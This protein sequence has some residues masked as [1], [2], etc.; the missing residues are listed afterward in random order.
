MPPERP[1][2]LPYH[3]ARFAQIT[4]PSVTEAGEA[5]MVTRTVSIAYAI[6]QKLKLA[7]DKSNHDRPPP[8]ITMP[9]ERA[10]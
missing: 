2:D 4:E 5:V 7:F 6:E 10:G 9:T 8:L 1:K 3:L